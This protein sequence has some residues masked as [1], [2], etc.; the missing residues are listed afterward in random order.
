MPIESRR[1]VWGGLVAGLLFNVGGMIAALSTGLAETFVEYGVE[2]SAGTAVKHVALRL[3]LGFVAVW[4]V[5]LSQRQS[6]RAMLPVVI[7]IWFCAY[8]PGSVVLHEL[9]VLSTGVLLFSL[10]WGFVES[11]V[12]TAVGVRA[13][14]IRPIGDLDDAHGSG[15]G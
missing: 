7:G 12:A 4:L 15:H 13:A 3:G 14:G 9:G 5:A 6:V 10:A 2:P 8:V 1:L 11:L